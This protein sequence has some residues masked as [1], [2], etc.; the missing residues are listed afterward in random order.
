MNFY[1]FILSADLM[2]KAINQAQAFIAQFRVLN[3]ELENQ[4]IEMRIDDS[5]ACQINNLSS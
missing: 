4:I 3:T 2:F 1:R 5:F